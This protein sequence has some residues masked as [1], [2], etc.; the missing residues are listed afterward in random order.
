MFVRGYMTHKFFL[1]FVFI[2][3]FSL[4][5]PAAS[6]VTLSERKKSRLAKIEA[7]EIAKK[8]EVEELIYTKGNYEELVKSNM[9]LEE[10]TAQNK[11]IIKQN[12][13]LNN[14]LASFVRKYGNEEGS[15]K[16]VDVPEEQEFEEPEFG[17]DFESIEANVSGKP[18]LQ[19][20][21]N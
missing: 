9:L 16:R 3:V 17:N 12:R 18:G 13:E 1:F 6:A 4:M 21:V 8:R 7:Q 10:I 5:S 19:I 20:E 14:L 11:T 2:A 15:A